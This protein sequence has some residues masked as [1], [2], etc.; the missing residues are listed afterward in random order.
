MLVDGAQ[1]EDSLG[2]VSNLGFSS[3][4]L[5]LIDRHAVEG[6]INIW[7]TSSAN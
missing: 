6:G 3:E 5:D 2:A 1:L 4:E 7:A